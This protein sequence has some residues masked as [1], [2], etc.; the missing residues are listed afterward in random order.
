MNISTDIIINWN[1]LLTLKSKEPH[2]QIKKGIESALHRTEY[3]EDP[4]DKASALFHSLI[5]NHYF[6][7]ANKRTALVALLISLSKYD[8][9]DDFLE[10]LILDTVNKKLDVEEISSRLRNN[11]KYS[12]YINEN[13]DI[14]N[15]IIKYSKL[16]EK[17]YYI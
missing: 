2:S 4:I 1:Y 16:I 8:F 15:V 14:Y 12:G 11:L 6:L 10:E 13:K 5:N 9:G 3:Y 7:Q 17:L